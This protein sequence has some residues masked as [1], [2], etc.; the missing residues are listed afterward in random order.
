M[1]D[2]MTTA[3]VRRGLKCFVERIPAAAD[4]LNALDGALGDGDLGVTL[5]R[6]A[7]R[8]KEE[9][10]H[11]PD[12]VGLA[13][14]LCAQAFTKVSASTYGTLLATGLMAAAKETKGQTLVPYNQ[15]P[16]LLGKALQAMSQRA[17]GKLGDKTILDAIESARQATQ[18]LEEADDLLA[19]ANRGV[20]AAIEAARDW[21]FQQGRARIF[22]SKGIGR[23]DPGMVAFKRIL[24]TLE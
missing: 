3:S 19:A 13:L 18:G 10:P 20:A 5:V 2:G 16:N 7:E 11:L 15:I 24:E 9:L 21:P 4:E 17:K 12:N 22:G 14:L 6:A 8:L 1:P 23:D